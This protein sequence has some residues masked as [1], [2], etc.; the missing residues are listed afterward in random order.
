[1]DLI[2]HHWNVG[3]A[4]IKPKSN[5]LVTNIRPSARYMRGHPFKASG[6]DIW[7]TSN[8]LAQ[9]RKA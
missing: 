3:H 8:T 2:H 1:M 7:D 5:Q 9:K 4:V 6:V